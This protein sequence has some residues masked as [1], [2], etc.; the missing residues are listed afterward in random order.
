[1]GD[2]LGSYRRRVA[3]EN[4]YGKARIRR[5]GYSVR[6]YV[7]SNGSGKTLAMVHDLLPTLIETERQVLST[8]RI[9]DFEDPRPCEDARCLSPDHGAPQHFAA[10]PRWIDWRSWADVLAVDHTDVLA[11]EI[12][13]V[14][15]SRGAMALPRA[16]ETALQQQ[17]KPENTFSWSG[18]EFARA[19]SVLRGVTKLATVCRGYLP[20]WQSDGLSAWPRNR[21]FVWGS[22]DVE[23]AQSFEAAADQRVKAKRRAFQ[24]MWGPGSAAFRAYSTFDSVGIVGQADSSGTCLTCGGYRSRAKCTCG[25]GGESRFSGRLVPVA[26]RVRGGRRALVVADAADLR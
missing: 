13:S 20:D 18:P 10:H 14:A 7:G 23:F 15:S 21:L 11:D 24:V 9:L 3:A 1:M 25:D 19:D 4:R 22:Y 17:R 12:S 5:R 6:A 16:V 8:V 26:E 2:V